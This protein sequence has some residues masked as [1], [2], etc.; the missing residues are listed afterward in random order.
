VYYTRPVVF[1]GL[2]HRRALWP[3]YRLAEN[4][5]RV[6]VTTGPG[7]RAQGSDPDPRPPTPGS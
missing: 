2:G 1:G 5:G 4:P 6:N 7:V 3:L